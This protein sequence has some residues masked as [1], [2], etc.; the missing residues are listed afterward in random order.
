MSAL[1]TPRKSN[2]PPVCVFFLKCLSENKAK[3]EKRIESKLFQKLSREKVLALEEVV[4][5]LKIISPNVCSVTE[6]K[7]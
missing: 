4:M 5:P 1:K 6:W 7:I 3:E 2:S